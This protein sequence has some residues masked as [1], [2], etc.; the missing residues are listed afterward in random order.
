MAETCP[1]ALVAFRDLT[2]AYGARPALTGVSGVFPAGATGL[3]GPNGAGKT[4]LLKTL[5]GFLAPSA[6]AVEAF[7]L[8]PARDPLGVR[9]RIGYLPEGDCHL[10]GMVAVE[11]V[12]FAGE[13]SGMPRGD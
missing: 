7:G 4:T 12:A 5:M 11:Q 10:A 8:D 1:D 3:L 13:L 2:V 6:G 9:Q